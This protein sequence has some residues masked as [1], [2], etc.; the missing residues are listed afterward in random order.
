MS[1]PSLEPLSENA[2]TPDADSSESLPRAA[3]QLATRAKTNQKNPNNR[4]N[5]GVA[6]LL[7]PYCGTIQF[8][9]SNNA[10]YERHL[11]FDNVLALEASGPRERFEAFARSIRDVL[12]QRW[13]RTEQTYALT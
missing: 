2:R 9:G 12:S 3:G 7:E 5:N 13:I 11:V 6:K 4:S 8:A 1:N 10:S